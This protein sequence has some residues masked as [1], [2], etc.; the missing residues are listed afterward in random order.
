[1]IYFQLA[2]SFQLIALGFLD[3]AVSVFVGAGFAV[4]PCAK[5]P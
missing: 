3:A 5:S 1:L 2:I 4:S